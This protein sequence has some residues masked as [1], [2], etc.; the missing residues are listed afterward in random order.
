MV[1]AFTGI[2]TFESLVVPKGSVK[3]LQINL[4]QTLLLMCILAILSHF[5]T[6][7]QTPAII[8]ITA[9]YEACPSIALP[10]PD[11]RILPK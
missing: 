9:P 3:D 8:P 1:T 6:S 5:S 2:N 10:S 7:N 11:R 4:N